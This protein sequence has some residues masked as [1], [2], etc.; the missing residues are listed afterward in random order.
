MIKRKIEIAFLVV[1]GMFACFAN[2]AFAATLDIL[3]FNITQ[4]GRHDRPSLYAGQRFLI[5][6]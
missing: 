3:E 1:A 6:S 5:T 4:L 2:P